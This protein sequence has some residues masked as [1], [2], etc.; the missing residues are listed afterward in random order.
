MARPRRADH[1]DGMDGAAETL[2]PVP[3]ALPWDPLPARPFREGRRTTAL[4]LR[5]LEEVRSLTGARASD[6]FSR[7][8]EAY[9][10][11][12][13]V[14]QVFESHAARI[15]V[16]RLKWGGEQDIL[17]LDGCTLIEQRKGARVSMRSTRT[18]ST[19][20]Y[21]SSSA[22]VRVGRVYVGGSSGTS[23]RTSSSRGM[24][25][26][27]PAPDVLTDIDTGTVRLTTRRIAFIGTMFTR[28]TT[29]QALLGW[30]TDDRRSLLIAPSNRSKA[31]IIETPDEGGRAFLQMMLM[32]TEGWLP[33]QR[34]A[35]DE[36]RTFR[37]D[38]QHPVEEVVDAIRDELRT[39]IASQRDVLEGL[40]AADGAGREGWREA[41]PALPDG[42]GGGL[43]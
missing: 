13:T 10:R 37:A 42:Y 22:G 11:V 15:D 1:G 26:S 32:A 2:D 38:E 27:L 25:I 16:E 14:A 7:E 12:V 9:A 6:E 29:F 5:L 40:A 28:N 20:T 35:F 21:Q 3:A 33:Q 39:A 17:V 36:D 24:T 19:G 30:T 41:L 31:W 4:A 8:L 43:A 18:T 34:R 23:S